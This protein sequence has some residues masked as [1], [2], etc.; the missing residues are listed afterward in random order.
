MVIFAGTKINHDFKELGGKLSNR[1]TLSV[2]EEKLIT[3][4]MMIKTLKKFSNNLKI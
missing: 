2:H 4:S 1:G 3:F